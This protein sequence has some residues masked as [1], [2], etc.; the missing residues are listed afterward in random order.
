MPR[1]GLDRARIVAAALD[2][3]DDVGLDRLTTRA[4]ADRLGVQSPAL[5]WHFRNKDE[6]VTAMAEQMMAG[7]PTLDADHLVAG[8]RPSR[9]QVAQWLVARSQAFRRVLLSRRDGARV[10]AGTVPP[11]TRL[12][13]VEVQ[14]ETMC[15]T[16]LSV[17]DAARAALA[18][19]RFVVGWVLEEQSGHDGAA[20]PVEWAGHPRLAEVADLFGARD[21]DAHFDACLTAVVDGLL[22]RR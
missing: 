2:L 14:L 4:L 3:L 12:P 11:A 18:L 20:G 10:H 17:L 6:L 5:Y 21:A 15:R 1:T 16:G 9:A 13:D 22:R 19:S 8:R 7:L